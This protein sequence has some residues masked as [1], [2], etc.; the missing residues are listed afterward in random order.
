MCCRDSQKGE[1]KSEPIAE[2][3]YTPPPIT[4]F[5]IA[6]QY[7]PIQPVPV[8][9]TQTPLTIEERRKMTGLE[10]ISTVNKEPPFHMG[11]IMALYGDTW[12]KKYT[13]LEGNFLYGEPTFEQ[14]LYQEM[15]KTKWLLHDDP[16][17][18]LSTALEVANTLSEI[19]RNQLIEAECARELEKRG[20]PK[21][22]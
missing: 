10:H 16:L 1:G 3:P 6:N 2:A 18:Y 8:M 13:Y 22:W 21:Y 5:E 12:R 11:A 20:I 7:R 15:K 9:K 14:V 17:L 4:Q 19:R